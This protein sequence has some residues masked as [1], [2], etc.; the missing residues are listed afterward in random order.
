MMFAMVLEFHGSIVYRLGR[1]PFKVERRVRFPL[2][3]L[4][5]RSRP[6]ARVGSGLRL[7]QLFAVWQLLQ[8]VQ[9]LMLQFAANCCV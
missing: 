8:T 6:D 4:A 3:L 9:K 5:H 7:R 1:D 2:E